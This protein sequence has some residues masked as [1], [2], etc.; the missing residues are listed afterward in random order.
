MFQIN[1]I[2]KYHNYLRFSEQGF[3]IDIT[4]NFL[5]FFIQFCNKIH[6]CNIQQLIFQFQEQIED[7]V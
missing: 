5:S 3:S 2:L 7:K 1:F 6:Y 4:S